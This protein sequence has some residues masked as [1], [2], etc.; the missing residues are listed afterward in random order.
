MEVKYSW[1]SMLMVLKLNFYVG[2]LCTKL[3]LFLFSLPFNDFKYSTTAH[4]T[5]S[6]IS[7]HV[8]TFSSLSLGHGNCMNHRFYSSFYILFVMLFRYSIFLFLFMDY[9][10]P[11]AHLE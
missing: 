9:V 4:L 5:C 6:A 3:A 2:K 11:F 1:F 8:G 7:I 10:E